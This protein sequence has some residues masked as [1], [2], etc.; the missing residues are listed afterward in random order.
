MEVDLCDTGGQAT[1]GCY[2]FLHL[3]AAAHSRSYISKVICQGIA[4]SRQVGKGMVWELL[5]RCGFDVYESLLYARVT[6]AR[7]IVEVL[8]EGQDVP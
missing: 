1:G 2:R 5:Q 8:D 7:T 4:F 6:E 3:P